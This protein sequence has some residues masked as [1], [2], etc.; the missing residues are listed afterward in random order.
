[1]GQGAPFAVP[2]FPPSPTQTHTDSPV[3]HTICIPTR[4]HQASKRASCGSC[5]AAQPLPGP[6]DR[7]AQSRCE[8]PPPPPDAACCQRRG[9]GNAVD[10]AGAGPSLAL[11]L[12]FLRGLCNLAEYDSRGGGEPTGKHNYSCRSRQQRLR[13][14]SAARQEQAES[15]KVPW[16]RR[17]TSTA[18]G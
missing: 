10:G 11:A 16:R 2:S 3:I 6:A 1:V 13:L 7:G 14:E 9:R 8:V 17:S 12:L 4:W 5:F 18:T 15:P